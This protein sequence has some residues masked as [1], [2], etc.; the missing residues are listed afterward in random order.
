MAHFRPRLHRYR[1]RSSGKLHP[2]AIVGI[3]L[4]AAIL[5]ALIVGNL[6]NLWLDDETY[7]KL[8]DGKNEPPETEAPAFTREVPTARLYPFTLGDPLSSLSSG[9]TPP[10]S[11]LSVSLNTPAG[12]LLYSSTVAD[13]Q[14]IL[15]DAKIPLSE[16][17]TKLTGTVPYV[18]GVFYPQALS[19]ESTDL[20]FA[21]TAN[22][23]ALLHE[24]AASGAS[25]ILLVG[26]PFETDAFSA[27]LSYVNAVSQALGE[28]P[29][30]VALPR[31]VATSALGWQIIPA[32]L[33]VADFIAY[34]LQNEDASLAEDLLLEANYYLVQYQMRL[35]IDSTQTELIGIAEA[36]LSDFQI[37]TA[38]PE[39]PSEEE[40][41]N[42][43]ET[44]R[45]VG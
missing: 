45:P 41:E 34:D 17:M 25:E 23:I 40:S 13:Y 37:V 2:L 44:V 9:N 26:L 36:T 30:G 15:G 6:L 32:L 33:E 21:A 28:T 1:S 35:L 24:F 42:E 8:T 39:V 7:Q 29:V 19:M 20:V 16:N 22:E 3:C 43:T 10:P 11:A 5:I 14:G 27:T 18:S 38:P 4:G 31:S 12:D